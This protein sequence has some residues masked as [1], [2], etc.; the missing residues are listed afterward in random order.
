MK[1]AMLHLSDAHIRV[2]GNN[3]ALK[4]AD[5]I[6]GT[7]FEA[8][9]HADLTLIIFTGDI[10]NSGSAAE[11][12]LAEDFIQAIWDL[13]SVESKG[14]VHVAI[15][16]GNH[17]CALETPN[18]T[19]EVALEYLAKTPTDAA[20]TDLV[21]TCVSV[22]KDFMKFRNRIC[23]LKTIASTPLW[24][25]YSCIIDGAEIRISAVNASWVS[26]MHEAPGSL[27]FPI[28]EFTGLLDAPVQLRIALMH[29]PLNWYCQYSYHPFRSALIQRADLV[30]SGHEHI[31]NTYVVDTGDS[32]T[33]LI[34]AG[35]LQPH[36]ATDP[37]SFTV[38]E[39]DTTSNL[40]TEKTFQLNQET[41]QLKD[42]RQHALTA[43]GERSTSK[44]P[45]KKEL[46]A[47]MLDPGGKFIHPHK[48]NISI[49]DLF[50]D[51]HLRE[52]EGD[53]SDSDALSAL[54]ILNNLSEENKFLIYG[55]EKAGKTTLLLK[56]FR[57]LHER[58]YV[59]LYLAADDVSLHSADDIRKAI[60]KRFSA[61][62][63]DGESAAST[64]KAKLVVFLD[65]I[66]RIKGA[67]ATL[68]RVFQVL[69][70]GFGFIFAAASSNF[71][72]S[73]LLSADARTSLA[74]FHGYELQRFG[75]QLRLLLIK[76]WTQCG[77]MCNALEL[78]RKVHR[79]EETLNGVVGKNLV[80]SLP[81]F[82]L[83]LLQSIDA[84]AST[85]IQNSGIA[86]YY[87][88]LIAKS[89]G[90]V[91]L[92]K[93]ELSEY[94]NFLSQLAWLLV[95]T[96]LQEADENRLRSF[97][98][99]YADRF[100]EIDLS[101]RLDFLIRARILTKRGDCYSF[102]YPYALYFFL[103]QYLAKNLADVQ[104]Q[105][106]LRKWYDS[107]HRRESANAILFLFHHSNDV[108]VVN[109]LQKIIRGC[110]PTT[111]P[112]EF[113]G[114]IRFLNTLIEKTS[115]LIIQEP[116]VAKN[117]LTQRRIS[118][119]LE[120]KET[121]PTKHKNDLDK[122]T[123]P[124]QKK[125]T[126]LSNEIALTI[127]T[128][129]LLGQ[130]TKSNYGSLE[131][132]TKRA[133]IAEVIDGPLRIL[134]FFIE[135]FSNNPEP[136]VSEVI[137]ILKN[138]EATIPTEK[139]EGFARKVAFQA[140]GAICT[141]LI[142]R[143]GQIVSSEKLS[144]DL[145]Q[146]VAEKGTSGYLLVEAASQF[147]RPGHLDLEKIRKLSASLKENPFAFAVL[148]SIGAYHIYMY[149]MREDE[150]Q[151][152]CALLDI[153]LQNANALDFRTRKMKAMR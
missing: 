51:P 21:E 1:I 55:E 72:Y 52:S 12:A 13:L 11:Y 107:L 111:I 134:R 88:Y 143:A 76:K 7:I 16:P 29:H 4:L 127:R 23:T 90:E 151:R 24:M 132:P 25:E 53:Q 75:Y 106:E 63:E 62:Y 97:N 48:E 3:P 54:S 9:R 136:F 60:T 6:A 118:D 144:G 28:A 99:I 45:L 14:P 36:K 145:A 103:G 46:I 80:P 93:D 135:E 141:G 85:D 112:L 8:C 96:D 129:S 78:D 50:I 22:Q 10:A 70:E 44:H 108:S 133:I 150:K 140:F 153:S 73:E 124:K 27:I 42:E 40:L 57:I 38:I 59:P 146:V 69:N 126:D 2:E 100:H 30:M 17:D 117:Q 49:D 113:N 83:I 89:L 95:S 115:K 120:R 79:V 19:R 67:Q 33:I 119:E 74:D 84:G 61:Q 92:K 91:G 138:K 34:E 18:K 105:N 137:Q 82:L 152:L 41:V 110:L 66:D 43:H 26:R 39:A 147:S 37:A 32:K 56:Y 128:A 114:D 142:L 31:P 94:N 139:L 71:E 87:R 5:K 102:S 98:K 64:P 65:D 81:I 125:G 109:E 86:E 149:E 15:V 123:D 130:I 20:N 131:R 58:D 68:A 121:N 148:Q 35:A 77:Q 47:T 104:V 122:F 101:K 116:D